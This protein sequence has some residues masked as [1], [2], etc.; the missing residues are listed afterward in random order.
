MHKLH[1]RNVL[2]YEEGSFNRFCLFYFLFW[3]FMSGVEVKRMYLL[4]IFTSKWQWCR[5]VLIQFVDPVTAHTNH[6]SLLK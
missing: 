2:I 3:V 4:N 1:T 6:I 5:A